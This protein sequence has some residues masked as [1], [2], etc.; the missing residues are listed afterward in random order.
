MGVWTGMMVGQRR[1]R[2]ASDLAPRWEE[3]LSMIQKTRR[4]GTGGPGGVDPAPG[5]DAGLLVRGDDKVPGGQRP[6]FPGAR[7]QIENAPRLVFELWVTR[8][9]P[10]PVAPRADGIFVQPA[11]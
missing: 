10:A 7:V 11:P 2:R 4:A 6:P 9:D 8:E 1:A 3:P 5:L